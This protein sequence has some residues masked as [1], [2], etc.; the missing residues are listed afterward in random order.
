MK[1]LANLLEL[2]R[3]FPRIL[4]AGVGIHR[5]VRA[6]HFDPVVRCARINR[7]QEEQANE[8]AKTREA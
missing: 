1:H 2:V 8:R 5:E 7:N 4:F 6:P 3:D